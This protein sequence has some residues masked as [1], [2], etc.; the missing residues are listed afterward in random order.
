MIVAEA[1]F[2]ILAAGLY[3]G[4]SRHREEAQLE[5]EYA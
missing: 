5:P 2:L 1:A 4:A 3:L